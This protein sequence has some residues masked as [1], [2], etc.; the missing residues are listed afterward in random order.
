MPTS[1]RSLPAAVLV[2]LVMT[3]VLSGCQVVRA[4]TRCRPGAAPGRD[5]SHVLLCQKGRWTRSMTI[6]QAVQLIMSTW[7]ANVE[8]LSGGGQT[9]GIGETFGEVAVRVTRRDG[10]PVKGADV[11]FAGPASGP[12]ILP[13]GFV[14]TDADGVA[15]YRP[16]ANS[17]LG[18]YP[19]TATVNG[20]T[21]PH[22][23]FGLNNG[24]A[25]ASS[26]VV[27]TGG[28]QVAAAGTQFDPVVV[29]AVDPFGNTVQY[30]N[31]EFSSTAP[32]V[33]FGPAQAFAG[34]DGLAATTIGT[35]NAAGAVP[36]TV[37]VAGS[38]ASTTFHLTVVAGPIHHPNSWSTGSGQTANPTSDPQFPRR[39]NNPLN[40]M[41]SDV[42]GNP[43]VGQAV[44]Y[45]IVPGSSSGTFDATST[46]SATILTGPDGIAAAHLHSNGA[47]GSFQ[48]VATVP[49]APGPFTF[50]VNS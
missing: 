29:K 44:H 22:V 6:G 28:G 38:N 39:V 34:E 18:G 45:S 43:V 50:T 16:V 2:V 20:G 10:S 11:V 33:W 3:T 23:T 40:V 4:G 14:P 32:G 15:R 1:R 7:P 25:S 30:K 41:L 5:A 46:T 8:L 49:G 21:S 19:V 31:F 48:V 17:A 24:A 26:I 36:I 13:S 9:V 37:R 27:V 35:G 47:V 12:S 42:F